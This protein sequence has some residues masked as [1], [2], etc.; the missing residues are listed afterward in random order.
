MW[1]SRGL[2]ESTNCR[3]GWEEKGG[4]QGCLLQT[5]GKTAQA[6]RPRASRKRSLTEQD[7]HMHLAMPLRLS[8]TCPNNIAAPDPTVMLHVCGHASLLRTRSAGAGQDNKIACNHQLTWGSRSADMGQKTRR[9]L[10]LSRN[11][12]S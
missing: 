8:S 3:E 5:E 12:T 10:Q 9:S 7:C 2:T 11:H 1:P 4:G 6:K